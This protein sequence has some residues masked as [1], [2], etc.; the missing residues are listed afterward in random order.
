[1]D[2]R[3][4]LG[5]CP[6]VEVVASRLDLGPGAVDA[7]AGWLHDDE[8]RRAGRFRLARDRRRYVVARGLLRKLLAARLGAH[9]RSVELSCGAHGKPCLAPGSA[10]G[11]LRFN[12]SH[13]GDLALFAFCRGRD[14]GVDV[15]AVL[16]LPDADAVARQFFSRGE[17]RAYRALEPRERV[18]GFFTFWTRKEAYLKALGGGLQSALSAFDAPPGWSLRSFSPAPGH[19]AALAVEPR[20]NAQG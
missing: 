11:D 18:L 20:G 15:E 19:T 5:H 3:K 9:P 8:C 12:V 17:L 13:S 7:L 2:P 10:A 6:A 14:I 1:M 4:A 16:P